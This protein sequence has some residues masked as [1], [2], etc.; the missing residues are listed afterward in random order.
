M[1]GGRR[2]LRPRSLLHLWS[3]YCRPKV[4]YASEL[5]EGVI[6][7][8]WAAK[9]ESLQT[10]VMRVALG[11]P[12]NASA[13]GMRAES[14][15]QTL[16]SRR[17]AARLTFFRKLATA[18]RGNLASIIFRCR[19]S[20]VD[21]GVA[22]RSWCHRTKALLSQLGLES[23]WSAMERDPPTKGG[24]KAIVQAAVTARAASAEESLVANS[25]S[26]AWYRKLGR[27]WMDDMPRYLDDRSSLQG[28]RLKTRLRL[29]C[30]PLMRQ[31][32]RQL[33][34]PDDGAICPL[35][36]TAVEDTQHFLQ[37]CP[38][39]SRERQVLHAILKDRLGT[40]GGPGTEALAQFAGGGEQ[41][42]LLMLG[43]QPRFKLP[44]QHEQED[45]EELARG[46]SLAEHLI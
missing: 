8:S 23:W 10:M 5:W 30:L 19:C 16:A 4:E 9:L 46:F 37:G 1:A 26:L 32:A 18:P 25:S 31:T 2:G 40:A 17:W 27:S 43:A 24:W 41:Q 39:F 22:T 34:W 33:G 11:A 42:L 20:Q 15:L 44:E 7:E 35:C 13:V 12:D 45:E 29:E 38:A 36:D 3:V 14:G 21:A 28:V 6:S